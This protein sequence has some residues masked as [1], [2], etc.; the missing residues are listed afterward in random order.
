MEIIILCIF[1]SPVDPNAKTK[2]RLSYTA[3]IVVVCI[4]I[5]A[6]LSTVIYWWWRDEIHLFIKDR[7]GNLEDSGMVSIVLYL[8][9]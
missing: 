2:T 8:N 4:F 1:V 7:F 3:S 6:L 5:V 9:N